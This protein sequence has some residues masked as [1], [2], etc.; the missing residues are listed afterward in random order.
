MS[1]A[2]VRLFISLDNLVCDGRSMRTLLAEWSRL[3]REP[4][5]VLPPLSATFR[6]YA[7]LTEQLALRPSYQRSLRYWHDKL[8][9]LPPAP[10]LPGAG[11]RRMRCRRRTSPGAR[12]ACPGAMAGAPAPCRA[13]GR[14]RQRAAARGLWRGAGQLVRD[15]A[16]HA[17]PDPVQPARGPPADRRAGRR[18]HLPGAARLRRHR[19]ARLRAAGAGHAAADLGRP[20]THAGVGRARAA[21]GR[22]PQPP[23]RSGGDAGGVHQRAGRGGR[24]RLGDGLARPLRLRRQPDAASVDRPASGRAQRCAGLQLGRG[25]RALPDGLL[26]D[27]FRAYRD[28]LLRLAE[29]PEAWQRPVRGDLPASRW[30]VAAP[31]ASAAQA[32]PRRMPGPRLPSTMRSWRRCAACWAR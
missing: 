29:Q 22:A 30:P 4:G 5:T 2:R 18:F 16:L 6:D 26:D 8:G 23:P 11:M 3:A 19:R 1:D 25:R 7:L 14:H 24:R 12:P 9:T 20:R 15:T 27:M 32:A 31:A 13:G 17:E 10:A 21:G 28:L